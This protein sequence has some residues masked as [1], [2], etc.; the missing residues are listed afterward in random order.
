MIGSIS[1]DLPF[2]QDIKGLF[3]SVIGHQLKTLKDNIHLLMYN[4]VTRTIGT[5]TVLHF[6]K[7]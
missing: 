7:Q 2:S 6:W 3:K 4:K 1:I 5:K